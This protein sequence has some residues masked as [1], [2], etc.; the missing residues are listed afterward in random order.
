M[1]IMST[2]PVA[3]VASPRVVPLEVTLTKSG[4][5][6]ASP[7]RV[8]RHTDKG[9]A[10]GVGAGGSPWASAQRARRW[11]P[12]AW[13]ARVPQVRAAKIKVWWWCSVFKLAGI[14]RGIA[15][16]CVA[17]P[18][19]YVSK[20]VFFP[21]SYLFSLMIRVALFHGLLNVSITYIDSN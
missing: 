10:P 15:A 4:A 8:T 2:A 5:Q 20:K 17:C 18:R 7:R 6:V 16:D 12:G 1:F 21:N 9:T 13:N 11:W 3:F 14:F 19:A